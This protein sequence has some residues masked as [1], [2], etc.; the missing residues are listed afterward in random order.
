MRRLLFE[1]DRYQGRLN[2]HVV[3]SCSLTD[4]YRPINQDIVVTLWCIVVRVYH[5]RRF[6]VGP[7]QP[8]FQS[9][10]FIHVS[11]FLPTTHPF[12]ISIVLNFLP[13]YV[14]LI[15]IIFSAVLPSL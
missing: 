12:I 2:I 9:L 13:H 1:N 15:N 14:F 7:A 4:N 5:L 3:Q 6:A 10:M 8:T 11:A